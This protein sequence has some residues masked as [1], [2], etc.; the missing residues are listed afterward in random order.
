[1]MSWS[2]L[3]MS[4]YQR[5]RQTPCRRYG[6]HY[7]TTEIARIHPRTWARGGTYGYMMSR[8]QECSS[9]LTF[10]WRYSVANRL[11]AKVN[12]KA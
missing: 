1:M 9:K 7:L 5:S 12:F 2:W 4:L 11:K 10:E 3:L 6:V 8:T